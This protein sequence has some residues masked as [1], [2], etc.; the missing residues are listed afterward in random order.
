MQYICNI[1]IFICIKD[2]YFNVFEGPYFAVKMYS[3]ALMAV[4]L[5]NLQSHKFIFLFLI[6]APYHYTFGVQH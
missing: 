6:T 1:F 2:Y 5:Q 4:P 3:A